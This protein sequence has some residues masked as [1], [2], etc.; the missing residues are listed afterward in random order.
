MKKTYKTLIPLLCGLIFSGCSAMV[1]ETQE[2]PVTLTWYVNYS[3]FDKTWGLDAVSAYITEET[4][5][6]VEYI[7]PSGDESQHIQSFLS[8]G[9]TADIITLDSW[10]STY[11]DFLQRD[12][13]APLDV[14]AETHKADFMSYTNVDTVLWFRQE[15]KHLYA[16]PNS[17]YPVDKVQSYATQ[18]FLVRKDIYEAIGSPDMSTPE[19]FLQALEDAVNFCPTVDG[20][21]LIPLGVQEFTSTGNHSLEDYLQNF[22]A[23][24]YEKYGNVV[25][26]SIDPEYK[27]WLQT[28]NEAHRRGL[29]SQDIFLDKRVQM[30]EKIA[31]GRYFAM[32]YQWSDCTE[33]LQDLRSENPE[34]SYI[35]VDGPKNSSGDDHRLAGSSIQ[36]WTLT[37]ISSH[38]TKQEEAIKL[39]S[40]LMGDE[41][42]KLILLGVENHG[43]TMT[44]GVPQLTEEAEKLL[45]QNRS[46]YDETYGGDGTHWPM[47]N[48]LY[49]YEQGYVFPE[50]GYLE[51]IRQWTAPYVHNFSIYAYRETTFEEEAFLAKKKEDQRRGEVLPALLLAETPEK[52]EEIWNDYIL[53]RDDFYL[54]LEARQEQMDANKRRA[55]GF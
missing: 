29:L 15:D 53:D 44:D 2:E 26:R 1:Q 40:Y 3:W 19:G 46:A 4:G 9:I 48:N 18:S 30:E 25:D 12:Y 20:M 32:L 36:G 24:P 6:N 27:I 47:M 21:P 49:G 34:G 22:L 11:G 5:I 28:L 23:I 14:L 7:V 43:Y 39:L 45:Q 42:Q 31:Q 54:V 50:E 37:G 41:G 10:D 17:S 35:A 16:Y 13:L 51:E 52:F 33:Q 38:S 55:G 8:K